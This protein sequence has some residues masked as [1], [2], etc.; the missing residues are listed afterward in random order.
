MSAFWLAVFSQ[1]MVWIQEDSRI[2]EDL[3][4]LDWWVKQAHPDFAIETYIMDPKQRQAH[5]FRVAPS[6]GSL[7]GEPLPPEFI[8]T[9]RIGTLQ[10]SSIASLVLCLS[11]LCMCCSEPT[12]HVS[13]SAHLYA[14]SALE[15]SH[16]L[17]HHCCKGHICRT[18]L[19]HLV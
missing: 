18:H 10:F 13:T 19:M 17:T 1:E 5:G 16:F 11:L 6:D 2:Q 3:W 9:S 8:C 15:A 7:A 14:S 12:A 4:P